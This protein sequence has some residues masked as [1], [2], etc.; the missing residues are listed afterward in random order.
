MAQERL[1]VSPARTSTIAVTI[2]ETLGR[3]PSG[4]DFL[5]RRTCSI[6][7]TSSCGAPQAWTDSC[8]AFNPKMTAA[9]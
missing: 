9:G 5:R 4:P 3:H 7:A 8:R 2:Y 1:G 6:S